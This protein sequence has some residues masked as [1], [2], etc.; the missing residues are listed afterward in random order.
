M[1][2]KKSWMPQWNEDEKHVQE[3][4]IF[5]LSLSLLS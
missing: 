3:Q 4:S 2:E 1:A 5:F